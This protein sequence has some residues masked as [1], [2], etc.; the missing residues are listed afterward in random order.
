MYFTKEK[1]NSVNEVEI[2]AVTFINDNNFSITFYNYGDIYNNFNLLVVH[3][4]I[5]FNRTYS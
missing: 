1:I 5:Y 4:I 3:Y 2:Y